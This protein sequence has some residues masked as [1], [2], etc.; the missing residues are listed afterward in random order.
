MLPS[1]DWHRRGGLGTVEHVESQRSLIAKPSRISLDLTVGP[2]RHVE[3]FVLSS[4][5]SHGIAQETMKTE[6]S[7]G[8]ILASRKAR[9]R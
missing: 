7:V 2:E 9:L 6:W 8:G 4:M 5:R 3:G 1:W